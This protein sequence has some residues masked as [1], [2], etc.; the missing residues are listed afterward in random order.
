MSNISEILHNSLLSEFRTPVHAARTGEKIKLRILTNLV[1]KHVMLCIREENGYRELD[2]VFNDGWTIEITAPNEP[3]LLWYSFKIILA[4]K[5]VYYGPKYGRSCG[6]G[7]V[8]EMQNLFYQI[9]VY[10]ANFTTPKKLASAVMYQIFPDR[11]SK[12]DPLNSLAGAEYHRSMGRHVIVHDD[13]YDEPIHTATDGRAYYDPCDYFLGD[14]RGIINKLDYLSELGINLIYL[15]PIFEAASNHRYNTSDYMKIDPILGSE[16]DFKELIVEANKRNIKIILDGVFSHTGADSVYFNKNEN[17]K[18]LGAYQ[19]KSS[20]YFKWY[21]FMD[22]PDVYKSWWGFNTLPEVDENE[23]SW[24]KFVISDEDSVMS[25]WLKCGAIGYRLDVADELPDNVIELMRSH[26]KSKSKDNFL[27]GE[28]WDDA[29]TKHSYGYS[30]KYALGKGLDSVMNYPLRNAIIDFLKFRYNAEDFSNFLSAQSVN[31]P[32]PMYKV[33][34][35]LLSS[36]DVARIRS[37]MQINCDEK[38]LSREDQ[39]DIQR[40]FSDDPL[41]LRLERIAAVI[42][43]SLAGIPSIYYGDEQGMTG[44]GDPFNRRTFREE[45][46]SIFYFYKLL[47]KLRKDVP[48]FTSGASS[49]ANIEDDIVCILRSNPNGAVLS[50]I[51]RS[52]KKQQFSL[53]LNSINNCLEASEKCDYSKLK[54]ARCLITQKEYAMSNCVVSGDIA[55]LSANMLYIL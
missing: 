45:D 52:D 1:A 12:G 8:T 41:I 32:P 10:D 39:F 34:M 4:D 51:N 26:I 40:D 48:E 23:S 6:L 37:A 33:L 5:T 16:T 9:T 31:Y 20:D 50:L 49:F 28:V 18:S 44:L 11:F 47:C 22:F 2:M 43:F 17:Y 53:D 55:P 14:I 13:F 36:H 25:H 42:Q 35:N 38:T 30:R 46:A 7:V 19:S 24:Q 54:K 27:L 29:T 15:N 3:T 21:N